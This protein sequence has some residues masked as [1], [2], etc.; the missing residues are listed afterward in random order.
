[1][2][3]EGGGE[4][5][6]WTR[7]ALAGLLGLIVALAATFVFFP[8]LLS[9]GSSPDRAVPVK[10]SA[11][12]PQAEVEPAVPVRLVI[13]AIDLRA[14]VLPI[15]MNQQGVLHPPD[16]V[17]EV[18]WWRRSAKPGAHKGQTVLTGHTVSSGGGVMDALGDLEP[19]DRV[20]VRSPKGTLIYETTRVRDYSTE[21]VAE[22]AH[23]LFGQ[24]REKGRLVLVTCTDWDGEEYRSNTIVFADPIGAR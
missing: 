7:K 20:R 1:V 11:S 2:S 22:H 9:P 13:P 12:V 8:G 18:G 15:E 21:E 10:A 23:D 14:P 4:P 16:D 24:D 3:I 6:P 19:G 17:S 5:T